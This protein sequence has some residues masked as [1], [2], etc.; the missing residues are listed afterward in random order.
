MSDTENNLKLIALNRDVLLKEYDVIARRADFNTGLIWTWATLLVSVNGAAFGLLH[1][2]PANPLVTS[3]VERFLAFVCVGLAGSSAIWWW[4]LAAR[5][6][7]EVIQIFYA[8]MKWIEERCGMAANRFIE[9]HD[10]P[11]YA[12]TSEQKLLRKA[13][14]RQ[15]RANPNHGI[16]LERVRTHLSVGVPGIWACAITIRALMVVTDG[17]FCLAGLQARCISLEGTEYVLVSILA[18]A[19]LIPLLIGYV[20]T[21]QRLK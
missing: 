7:H 16:S 18:I 12:T 9:L 4:Q 8:R 17:K 3:Q 15:N 21:Q 19:G 20:V 2:A 1:Q 5:R 14:G 13:T 11:S 10:D 6:W